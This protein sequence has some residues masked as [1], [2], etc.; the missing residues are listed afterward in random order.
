MA[1]L[2][3]WRR[4]A[5]TPRASV[6][7]ARV[8]PDQ[9]EGAARAEAHAIN[10]AVQTALQVAHQV[11]AG[12]ALLVR[13]F[14]EAGAELALQHAVDAPDFLLLTKLQAVA[15][16]LRLAG[17]PVLSGNEVALFDGALFGVAA[18]AFEE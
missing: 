8:F 17:L 14:F 15:H 9:F 18:L 3:N 7:G 16:D 5:A 2:R 4:A 10:H 11:V 12:D 6:T 13:G 1:I